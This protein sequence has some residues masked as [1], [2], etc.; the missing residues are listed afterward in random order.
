MRKDSGN[1]EHGETRLRARFDVF[2]IDGC[3]HPTLF[4]MLFADALGY[5]ESTVSRRIDLGAAITLP[6]L[7]LIINSAQGGRGTAPGGWNER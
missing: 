5:W 4:R 6:S 3:F 1:D 7:K 2:A